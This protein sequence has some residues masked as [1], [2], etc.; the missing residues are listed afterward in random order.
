[1]KSANWRTEL[2]SFVKSF[3][4]NEYNFTLKLRA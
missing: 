3:S 1:M 4:R 2:S